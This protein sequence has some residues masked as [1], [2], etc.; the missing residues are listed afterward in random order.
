[1]GYTNSW[2]GTIELRAD[3]DITSI[4]DAKIMDR[5]FASCDV[6]VYTYNDKKEK[7][8]NIDLITESYS[9]SDEME[10]FFDDLKPFVIGGLVSREGEDQRDIEQYIFAS[11]GSYKQ[12]MASVCFTEEELFESFDEDTKK[13]LREALVLYSNVNTE[14]KEVLSR[15]H[16]AD[17][18]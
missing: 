17:T 6:D 4:L 8:L 15:L 11:D 10:M 12:V 9:A 3:A 14:A 13:I 18:N 1:M 2:S 7:A 16:I 5:F